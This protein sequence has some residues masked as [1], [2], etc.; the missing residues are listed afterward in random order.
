[1]SSKRAT[2]FTHLPVRQLG[3]WLSYLIPAVLWMAPAAFPAEAAITFD[4]AARAATTSTGQMSLSW[5]HTI[6]SGANR[7]L[8]I[9]V[10][11]ANSNKT[12]PAVASVVC[13]GVAATAVP[14]SEVH[15]GGT[16]IIET[17]LF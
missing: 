7:I 15:G 14:N 17:Q 16:G 1:M 9:G 6:A 3:D 5:T 12:V 2:R 10:S 8:V 13:N 11:M 4:T